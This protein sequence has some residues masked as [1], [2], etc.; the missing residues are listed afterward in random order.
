MYLLLIAP[1]L[2]LTVVSF[3]HTQFHTMLASFSMNLPL[4]LLYGLFLFAVVVG[5]LLLLFRALF[6]SNLSK[7]LIKV[8]SA[9][10]ILSLIVFWASPVLLP[11]TEVAL[12]FQLFSFFLLCYY[13]TGLIASWRMAK[14]KV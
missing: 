2:S 3:L 11:P 1:F 8:M 7:T 10:V 14:V 9:G 4:L 5:N 13:G 6:D 12:R